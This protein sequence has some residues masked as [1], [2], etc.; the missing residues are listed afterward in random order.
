ME[1]T[2]KNKLITE[3]MGNEIEET[4]SGLW[5]YAIK[6]GDE[7]NEYVEFY[8]A[9]ELKYHSSWDWLMPVVYSI[10]NNKKSKI[11]LLLEGKESIVPYIN[12]SHSIR[13]HLLN[14]DIAGVYEGVVSFIEWYN[15]HHK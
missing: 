6:E 9:K 3:Y 1:T 8:E 13:M 15:K 5:V 10:F 14:A 11:L 7:F 12:A 2:L 4:V